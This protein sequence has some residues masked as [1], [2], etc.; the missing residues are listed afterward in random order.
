MT[1]YGIKYVGE[2]LRREFRISK[3]DVADVTSEEEADILNFAEYASKRL[4][5]G[6]LHSP[7]SKHWLEKGDIYMAMRQGSVQGSHDLLHAM[8]AYARSHG[9][10]LV[11][12]YS[13]VAD[14]D[15]QFTNPKA[16]YEELLVD[17]WEGN[18]TRKFLNILLTT[19]DPLR[20][21][22]ESLPD[23]PEE[24]RDRYVTLLETLSSTKEGQPMEYLFRAYEIYYLLC[25]GYTDRVEEYLEWAEQ[26]RDPQ[27][28]QLFSILYEN[29]RAEK[30]DPK[31]LIKEFQRILSPLLERLRT[32][33]MRT[34]TSENSDM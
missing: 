29:A 30:P 13:K 9:E 10:S 34:E 28:V 23:C 19:D 14:E 3:D 21:L 24:F 33:N 32:K 31:F 20:S 27:G 18:L 12:A 17:L 8:F 15:A 26:H 22:Q 1:G 25:Y 7:V 2:I 16:I 4:A 6:S 11:P 5:V